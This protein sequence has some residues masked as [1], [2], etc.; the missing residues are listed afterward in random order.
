MISCRQAMAIHRVYI[1]ST[2]WLLVFIDEVNNHADLKKMM[3]HCTVCQACFVLGS[4]SDDHQVNNGP[5][6][7]SGPL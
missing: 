7:A 5:I 3:I 2:V 4:G 1:A 6:C